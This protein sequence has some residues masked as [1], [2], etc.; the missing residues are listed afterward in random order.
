VLSS[1]TSGGGRNG[2]AVAGEGGEA[3]EEEEEEEDVEQPRSYFLTPGTRQPSAV[4][5]A[6]GSAG[7]PAAAVAPAAATGAVAGGR[8]HVTAP[9]LLGNAPAGTA[10]R[11]GRPPRTASTAQAAPTAA[12]RGPPDVVQLARDATL[13]LLGRSGAAAAAAAAPGDG[14]SHLSVTARTGVLPLVPAPLLAPEAPAAPL[15]PRPAARQAPTP[16]AAGRQ[17]APGQAGR[18]RH[19]H[20]R[21]LPVEEGATA[22]PP[23]ALS[24]LRTRAALVAAARQGVLALLP[25][26]SPVAAGSAPAPRL[27]VPAA[28]AAVQGRPGDG[29]GSRALLPPKLTLQQLLELVLAQPDLL[30]P[31][32]AAEGG[33]GG[34]GAAGGGGGGL[35]VPTVVPHSYR[36]TN[37]QAAQLLQQLQ[38]ARQQQEQLQ[39][40]MQQEEAAA[41]QRLEQAA[42]SAAVSVARQ[43]DGGYNSTLGGQE[44][45]ADPFNRQPAVKRRRVLDA[46]DPAAAPR[47]V[48]QQQQQHVGETGTA[49]GSGSGALVVPAPTVPSSIPPSS[50]AGLTVAESQLGVWG[51]LGGSQAGGGGLG[52][53]GAAGFEAGLL[54]W[55]GAPGGGEGGGGGWDAFTQPIEGLEQPL[56]PLQEASQ[57]PDGEGLPLGQ[58][59]QQLCTEVHPGSST[60]SRQ[61]ALGTQEVVAGGEEALRSGWDQQQATH[62]GPGQQPQA[63]MPAATAATT[64]A[65]AAA[66][67]G[68]GP[69][70][71]SLAAAGL[72]SGGVGARVGDIPEGSPLWHMLQAGLVG[73]AEGPLPAWMQPSQDQGATQQQQH[74]QQQHGEQRGE[75][76]QEEAEQGAEQ[77]EEERQEQEAQAGQQQRAVIAATHPPAAP[78][79]GQAPGPVPTD[80]VAVLCGRAPPPQRWEERLALLEAAA[81]ALGV[82]APSLGAAPAGPQQLL[83]QQGGAPQ[84]V[85]AGGAGMHA[86][87]GDGVAVAGGSRP[88][89]SML[90]AADEV[91]VIQVAPPQERS[92]WEALT[93]HLSTAAGSRQPPV[94]PPPGAAA[95]A[96]AVVRHHPPSVA[97][98]R[99]ARQQ[100]VDDGEAAAAQVYQRAMAEAAAAQ[101]AAQEAA[102]AE[103]ASLAAAQETLRQAALKQQRIRQR[104]QALNQLLAQLVNMDRSSSISLSDTEMSG[105]EV[106]G[107]RRGPGQHRHLSGAGGLS[108]SD[109]G[110]SDTADEAATAGRTPGRG[111]ARHPQGAAAAAAAAAAAGAAA[112]AALEEA[113]AQAER[114]W[115]EARG[116]GRQRRSSGSSDAQSLMQPAV[117]VPPAAARPM[118]GEAVGAYRASL[119][120]VALCVRLWSVLSAG[121]PL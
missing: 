33:V 47:L 3:D 13:A 69:V 71:P 1:P 55:G 80:L 27:G 82:P 105:D 95:P 92:P 88:A 81:A 14:T 74:Q 51:P 26:L 24:Q 17:A 15:Q 11:R 30:P 99:L 35:Q 44:G 39:L 43:Q 72:S 73:L 109:W 18:R 114:G 25:Y 4:A 115:V 37:E 36:R 61:V 64:A 10:R 103:A 9:R 100:G 7:S 59:Q 112:A 42:M 63:T 48:V 29:A 65:A 113:A 58:Q 50:Q 104:K 19:A 34:V 5:D 111:P 52:S 22:P 107:G 101:Q 119:L 83:P 38:A 31:L 45:E 6:S 68:M 87:A 96:A 67:A 53:Q 91:G 56:L 8:R 28:A 108:L 86:A 12:G 16:A 40:Q 32:P 78:A 118:T 62:R 120:P 93:R 20:L 23:V 84:E 117:G 77:D 110:L 85:H 76:E 57:A 54:G 94:Q 89:G 66:A 106:E 60:L 90:E 49:S 75:A 102:A 21:R 97:P 70:S 46:T 121:G 2:V 41:Q 98:A 116:G 79:P